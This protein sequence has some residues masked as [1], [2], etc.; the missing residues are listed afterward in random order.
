MGSYC[1][2]LQ[3]L[4]KSRHLFIKSGIIRGG[5]Y[6]YLIRYTFVENEESNNDEGNL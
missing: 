6:M 3:K 4:N 2:S 5:N 1:F